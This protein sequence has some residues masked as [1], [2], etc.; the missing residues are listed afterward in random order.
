MSASDAALTLA[1]AAGLAAAAGIGATLPDLVAITRIGWCASGVGAL[2]ADVLAMAR[3]SS[4]EKA[5][6]LA[7]LARLAKI[8]ART[9]SLPFSAL[10][11]AGRTG[12][13]GAALG[14]GLA[15]IG[16][17]AAAFGLAGAGAC[18]AAGF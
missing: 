11:V 8:L 3:T 15:G 13:A 7:G 6:G 14:A 4:K 2:A 18:L 10:E 9:A 17:G 12:T 5:E 16:A 1:G